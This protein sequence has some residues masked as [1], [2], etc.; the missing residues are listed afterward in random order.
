YTKKILTRKINPKNLLKTGM[1][2]MMNFTDNVDEIP[3]ELRSALQ[4]LDENK[5]TV[6]TEFKNIEKTNQLIKSST[7]NLMLAII[8]G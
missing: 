5:F 3:K 4:K 7:V 2:R 8:L 1:D 6:S